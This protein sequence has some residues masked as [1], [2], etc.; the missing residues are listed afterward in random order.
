MAPA[1]H[2]PSKAEAAA[3]CERLKDRNFFIAK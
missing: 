1:R 2:E 3:L